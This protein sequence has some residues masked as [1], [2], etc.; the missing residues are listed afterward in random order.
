MEYS[1]TIA[2]FLLFVLILLL[3]IISGRKKGICPQCSGTNIRITRIVS[4]CESL[5]I[6]HVCRDCDMICKRFEI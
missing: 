2:P 6:S 1:P 4:D 3:E 5:T